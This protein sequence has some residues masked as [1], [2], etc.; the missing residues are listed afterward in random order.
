MLV[1]KHLKRSWIRPW[2]KITT[3]W[4]F[5]QTMSR[6]WTLRKFPPHPNPCRHHMILPDPVP[7]P[8]V[9]QQATNPI[10]HHQSHTWL[11]PLMIPSMITTYMISWWRLTLIMISHHLKPNLCIHLM[12]VDSSLAPV[13]VLELNY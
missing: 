10:L 8:Y 13:F 1:A 4:H 2:K 5:N 7:H 11:Q 3:M 12:K 6:W 9:P